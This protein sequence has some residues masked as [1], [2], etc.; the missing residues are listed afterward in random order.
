MGARLERLA[1]LTIELQKTLE[2][3]RRIGRELRPEALDDLG[4]VNALIALTSRIDRQT[5]LRVIRELG[6]EIRDLDSE[7]EL[8]VYRVAQ[9]AL[10]NA[11]RHAGAATALVA[12]HDEHEQVILT[13]RDDGTGLADGAS[14]SGQGIEGMRERAMLV[15][16]SLEV[17]PHPGGGTQ[18]R[19]V[20]PAHPTA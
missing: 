10:T 17:G 7:Q 13:V 9:E 15:G 4:L 16:A 6:G 18:V 2:D 11:V 5:D 12:L 3:V 8:V 19:L 20:L 14:A 1:V